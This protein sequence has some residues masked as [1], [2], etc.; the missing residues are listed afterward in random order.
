MSDV[1]T[2]SRDDD[3]SSVITIPA[4]IQAAAQTVPL[5]PSSKFA[6][7]LPCT[8]PPNRSA[9]HPPTRSTADA[10]ASALPSAS[11]SPGAHTPQ[12]TCTVDTLQ[13]ASDALS[14]LSTFHPDATATATAVPTAAAELLS[15]IRRKDKKAPAIQ[16]PHP[17]ST[18]L[19]RCRSAATTPVPTSFLLGFK[20]DSL[21]VTANS[22]RATTPT[23]TPSGRAKRQRRER[24]PA[25]PSAST[26][27][28][29]S[30]EQ[31]DRRRSARVA[32]AVTTTASD[33][34]SLPNLALFGFSP[35]LESLV[36]NAK[37]TDRRTRS[38]ARGFRTP[39]DR[40]PTRVKRA[41]P[42][43][44]AKDADPDAPDDD[45]KSE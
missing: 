11:T 39:L 45:A 35:Y 7:A 28:L 14:N 44:K 10:A 3:S 9:S 13:L 34:P 25:T 33:S 19:A 22:S 29:P 12:P 15:A 21:D 20:H 2:E 6:S 24:N 4:Q 16:S 26:S 42:K 32:K 40:G 23:R 36:F 43:S 17:G 18:G 31:N 41:A 37:D 5:S 1:V 30:I 8:S 27:A 38:G